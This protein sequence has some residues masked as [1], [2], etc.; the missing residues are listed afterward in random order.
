[1]M[2]RV[3]QSLRPLE[4]ARGAGIPSHPNQS[5]DNVPTSPSDPSRSWKTGTSSTRIIHIQIQSLRSCL[6]SNAV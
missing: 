1:M 3:E 6:R 5:R 2:D 4:D